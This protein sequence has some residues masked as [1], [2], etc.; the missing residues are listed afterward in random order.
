[1]TSKY[2]T[3]LLPLIVLAVV[4]VTL[5]FGLSKGD[6]N[7]QARFDPARDSNWVKIFSDEFDTAKLDTSKWVTCYDWKRTTDTGC[8][9]DGNNELQV[10]RP[11]QIVIS[12]GKA[13]LTAERKTTSQVARGKQRQF[14]YVSGMLSTGRSDPASDV[15][16][17]ARYGYFEARIKVPK[18]QGIWPA[19][20]LLPIDKKWP[21]EIDIM[22]YIGGKPREVL[23]T[24]HWA[25]DRGKHQENSTYIKGPD[26]SE[27]WHTYAVNWQPHAIE[28]FIDGQLKKTS[29]SQIPNEPMELI[30]NLA[31]GGRLP[32]YPDASTKFPV[33]MEV[34]YVR[35]YGLKQ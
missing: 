17:S 28:W 32:G 4:G 33:S 21:P 9:N 16:W 6:P 1:M 23:L 34:D 12:G 25:D 29:T 13:A 14:E 31:V 7:T 20:W 5:L 19:F 18:G 11:E 30:V 3:W 15:K 22:E 10:Y 27:G 24:H 2:L 8:T 26:Y 35:A